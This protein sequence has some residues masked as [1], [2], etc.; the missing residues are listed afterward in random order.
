MKTPIQPPHIPDDPSRPRPR[1]TPAKGS[2]AGLW[3]VRHAE[4]HADWEGRAYGGLDIPLSAR[5]EAQ[6]ESLGRA[7]ARET[8]TRILSSSLVRASSLGRA[9]AA[10]TRAPLT[11]DERLREV[12]RGNWQGLPTSEFRAR[13]EADAPSFLSDPWHWKGHGGES[14]ADVFARAHAA[15]AAEL[16]LV[17]AGTLV[18][19]T[20]YN[21]IRALITGLLGLSA[22]ESFA[23]RTDTARATL[24]ID[25]PGGW[26]LAA[27]NVEDPAS[28]DA[29][30]TPD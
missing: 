9:I 25:A 16:E 26:R 18:V 29:A 23:L 14:D 1:P 15:I 30:K 19:T 27:L 10:A 28:V 20:H 21:V 3:L 12:S 8:I 17:A 4:V 13:W 22:R 7:F 24:L 2:G 6:T 5:G 11:I